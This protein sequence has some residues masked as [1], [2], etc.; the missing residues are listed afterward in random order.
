MTPLYVTRAKAAEMCSVS[1]DTIR[2]ALN[3]GQL[4]AK[5]TGKGGGGRYLIA[6]SALEDWFEGLADA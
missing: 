1:E 4:R 2:R 5:R 3:S 6:V